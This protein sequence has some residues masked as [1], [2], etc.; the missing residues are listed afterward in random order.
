MIVYLRDRYPTAGT[1]AE[2]ANATYAGACV[3][4]LALVPQADHLTVP[5]NT[6][7]VARRLDIKADSSQL[8]SPYDIL[9]AYDTTAYP[10]LVRVR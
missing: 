8:G 6:P 1:H 2:I 5:A 9:R 4:R 7:L 10:S 3:P